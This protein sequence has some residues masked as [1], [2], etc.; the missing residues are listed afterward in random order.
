MRNRLSVKKQIVGSFLLTANS[1]NE[2]E[3]K[4]EICDRG[5]LCTVIFSLSISDR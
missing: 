2:L 3:I 5:I 4:F 1:K